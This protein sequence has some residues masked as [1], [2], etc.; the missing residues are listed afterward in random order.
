MVT[1]LA[2]TL[3]MVLSLTIFGSPKEAYSCEV[4][5][6]PPVQDTYD[7]SVAVFSGKVA[8][9]QNYTVES[10]GDWHLV[11]FEVDRYWKLENENTDYKQIIL[12]TSPDSGACGY[13]FEVAK[14]YLVY[15]TNW[16]HDP[17][18]LYTSIGYR[19]QPLK[20]AQED[21]AFLGEGKAPTRESSWSEQISKI[22]IEPWP[23]PHE[24]AQSMVLSI[25]GIGAV[26]A[27]AAAFFSLRRLKDKK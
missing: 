11:S 23:K 5:G 6:I 9:I 7:I 18:Q 3:M 4:L 8:K 14:T 2:I 21:L 16:S 22:E 15:A 25:V 19:N 13:E 20:Q 12:F 17:N 27:G 24:E 10:F 1:L 26:I